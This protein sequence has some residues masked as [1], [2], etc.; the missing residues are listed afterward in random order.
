MTQQFYITTTLPYVNAEPHIGFALE[1]IAAD[2]IARFQKEYLGKE[3]IFNTGTDE[4]GQKIYQKAQEKNEDPQAYVDRFAAEFKKLSSQLNLSVTHFIRTTNPDHKN[5]AQVFWNACIASGDIY[6]KMYTIN[7][8]VG[9]ELEKQAS[10]LVEGKCPLHPN[11]ALEVREEENYFFAF[12][13]YQQPLHEYYKS[14]PT[15]VHPD[16]KMKEITA[17]VAG[18]L[19]DFS[20]SRLKE[21]MPWGVP[22][23]ND[24]TH[25]MYV[26]FDALVNYISTLGWPKDQATFTQYWPGVQAAG[27][28]N[29]RQQAAMWQA[30]LLSA[31]LPPSKKIL[32]NGFI[33]IGGQKMSKSLGNVISPSE[34][35]E[36]YGIDGTRYLLMSLGPFTNDMDVTWEKLDTTYTAALS[37]GLGNVCS[38]V[39]KLCEKNGGIFSTSPQQLSPAFSEAL[40]EFD[41]AGAL[42]NIQSKVSQL[43]LYFSQTEPWKK[44]GNEQFD[45]L[46]KALESIRQIVLELTVFMP[47]TAKKLTVHFGGSKITA[48]APLFPRLP[49]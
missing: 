14:N 40:N 48:L 36:K 17:F 45:I 18:G 32:I 21:K 1:I 3:V 7:Y 20:I 43:D 31:K 11:T 44:S 41:I 26:W 35:C 47:D 42:A 49:R 2:V 19:Q 15:F 30:M 34:M 24:D 8:C 13:K 28:D 29:L 5:A 4:H 6:K 37:N 39:A 38:R 25:V 9:C 27:K 23:P 16:S 22:V 33:S 46:Q 12:S 10:E